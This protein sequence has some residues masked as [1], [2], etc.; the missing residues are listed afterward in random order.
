VA[1][2]LVLLNK[3]IKTIPKAMIVICTVVICGIWLEHHLLIGPAY[4]HHAASLPLGFADVL[5]GLG[6]LGLLAL[7]VTGY[8]RQF[9]E[10]LETSAGGGK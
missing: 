8:L 9:P 4:N 10:L 2:F 6:F 3:K 5:V 7:T 1:P